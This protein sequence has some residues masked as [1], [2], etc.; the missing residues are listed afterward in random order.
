MKTKEPQGVLN[1]SQRAPNNRKE[2]TRHNQVFPKGASI[3]GNATKSVGFHVFQK[4]PKRSAGTPRSSQWT[5]EGTRRRPKGFLRTPKT[6]L[7]DPKNVP[8]RSQGNARGPEDAP[9][10]PQTFPRTAQGPAKTPKS[11]VALVPSEVG[12]GSPR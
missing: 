6:V 5:L 1:D 3:V 10:H 11:E 12:P 9:K 7:R 4:Q 8:R 2:C